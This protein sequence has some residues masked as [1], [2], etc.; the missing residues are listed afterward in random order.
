MARRKPVSEYVSRIAFACLSLTVVA[1]GNPP[2]V[3]KAPETAKLGQFFVSAFD[4]EMNDPLAVAGYLDSLD[5]AVANPADPES[6]ATAIAALDA[7]VWRDVE[8]MGIPGHQGLAY[9]S[10]DNYPLVGDRLRNVFQAAGDKLDG[11]ADAGNLPFIRGLIASALHELA[12]YVGQDQAAMVWGERRGCAREAAIIA[13]LDWAALRGLSEASPISGSGPFPATITGPQP[14]WASIQPQITPANACQIDPSATMS[15]SGMRA[16]V[17]DLENPRAQRIHVALSSSSAAVVELAGSRII[18]RGF[19]SGDSFVTR[20]AK[21]SVPKGRARIVVRVG[22][23]NDGDG[24]ELDVWGEDGLPIAMKAPNAGDVATV[25][26]ISNVESIEIKPMIENES[27]VMVAV[28]ALLG[29][30]EGRR[31]E[32]LLESRAL[33]EPLTPRLSLLASRATVQADDLPDTKQIERLR[34][35]TDRA[36]KS[37]PAAWEALLM[38]GA[39]TE[40]R[41]AGEGLADA[42]TELGVTPP[43]IKDKPSTAKNITNPMLLAYVAAA[44]RRGQ[45]YDIAEEAYQK[46]ETLRRNG[47]SQS[48][49]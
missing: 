42:L 24:I 36:L 18:Q 14:F 34:A 7:L 40:R 32:H 17:V 41:R 16:I 20:L 9:R 31:A 11:S 45:I 46:L 15:L 43:G 35:F 26:S 10:R 8:P 48:G 25:T 28:A 5:R 39:L 47:P 49:V 4:G 1:C 22:Y 23:M 29:M 30:G 27:S 2:V 19:D 12:L 37:H 21:A 13:P 33:V 44:A 3:P 6:L 38:R